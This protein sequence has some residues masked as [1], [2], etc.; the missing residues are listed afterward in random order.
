MTGHCPLQI[1]SKFRGVDYVCGLMIVEG[2]E[3][4]GERQERLRDNGVICLLVSVFKVAPQRG[5]ARP[6][7]DRHSACVQ[8]VI[9]NL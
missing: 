5:S 9:F 2:K 8:S 6:S 1:E 3:G 7:A 4:G